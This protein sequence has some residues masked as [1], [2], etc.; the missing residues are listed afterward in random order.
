LFDRPRR[1]L[2]LP[3]H[4]RRIIAAAVALNP[5][6][7]VAL[8]V[9]GTRRT[10]GF[11]ERST[12]RRFAARMHAPTIEQ[13][14]AAANVGTNVNRAAVG[15]GR[16]TTCLTR[17]LTTQFLLRRQGIDARLRIGVARVDAG[18]PTPPLS[19]HAWVEVDG[20]PVNDHRDVRLVY[21]AFPLEH[22][23]GSRHSTH[24]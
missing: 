11:V 2:A 15:F 24:A 1:F 20:T 5:A 10:I 3:G 4:D 22:V 14:R 19:F 16:E 6:V 18:G 8:R 12:A 9:W 7:F 23:Q 21:A 17:S 13:V